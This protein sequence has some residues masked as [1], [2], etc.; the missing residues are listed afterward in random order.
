MNRR[1]SKSLA[2]SRANQ[3]EHRAAQWLAQIDLR[4]T[5]EVR[6]SLD[7]WL[8]LDPRHAAAFCRLSVAWKRAD[9]LRRLAFSSPDPDPDLLAPDRPDVPPP[10][11]LAPP[12]RMQRD[13]AE[14]GESPAARILRALGDH[15]VVIACAVGAFQLAGLVFVAL[16]SSP[17]FGG[18][19][20]GSGVTG[21]EITIMTASCLLGAAIG[22]L[23]LRARG[24]ER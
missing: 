6:A 22:R 5:P 20:P 10:E 8:A 15:A 21:F 11:Q 13:I 17:S 4:D 24:Q 3:V 19:T 1:T 9:A 16:E 12:G 2:P 23:S 18:W 14:D 7:E